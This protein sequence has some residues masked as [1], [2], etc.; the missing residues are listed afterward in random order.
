MAKS[1]AKER[2]LKNKQKKHIDNISQL[3]DLVSCDNCFRL[4]HIDGWRPKLTK[5]P[6]YNNLPIK[7]DWYGYWRIDT[8]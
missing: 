5:D 2:W 7:P 3:D 4:D 6:K 8:I 1:I